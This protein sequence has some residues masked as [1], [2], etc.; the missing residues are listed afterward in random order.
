MIQGESQRESGGDTFNNRALIGEHQS[1]PESLAAF[2]ACNIRIVD[3][4][5]F[6]FIQHL[7]RERQGQTK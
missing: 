2:V 6:Q 5:F 7:M 1:W 3:T 4:K